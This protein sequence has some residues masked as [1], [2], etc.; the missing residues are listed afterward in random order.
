[1]SECLFWCTV[2]TDIKQRDTVE[3]IAWSGYCSSPS[4]RPWLSLSRLSSLNCIWTFAISGLH[5]RQ[6]CQDRVPG[7]HSSKLASEPCSLTSDALFFRALHTAT[8]EHGFVVSKRRPWR[9]GFDITITLRRNRPESLGSAQGCPV[10][11]GRAQ[12]KN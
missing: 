4:L 2:L 12:T 11:G 10:R 7:P 9:I 6:R 8:Q 1:M 3:K 5:R